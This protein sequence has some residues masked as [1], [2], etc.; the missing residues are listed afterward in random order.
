M[1]MRE[2]LDL[3]SNIGERNNRHS[4]FDLVYRPFIFQGYQLALAF[5]FV[6][7]EFDRGL[8]SQSLVWFSRLR[9]RDAYE[10][11][12]GTVLEWILF[13]D[14]LLERKLG[15]VR[16]RLWVALSCLRVRIGKL[17]IIWSSSM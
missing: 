6:R 17:I 13:F 12:A 9:A 4:S 3:G 10:M 5:L 8:T 2:P 1:S 11:K 7:K 14:F 15:I 16:M